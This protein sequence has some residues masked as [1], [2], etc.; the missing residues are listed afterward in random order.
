MSPSPSPAPQPAQPPPSG[1]F[2]RIGK[3]PYNLITYQKSRC[4]YLITR[5][6]VRVALTRGDRTVD[7]MIQAARSGKQ[8]IIEGAK[9]GPTSRETEI[10]LTN[11]AKAS[12]QELREDFLDWLRAND[13]PIWVDGSENYTKARHICGRHND[14]AFYKS[15]I[16]VRQPPAI[17]NIAVVL[18][19]QTD[20][21]LYK[22]LLRLQR[23]F[24]RFG[25]I[26][27]TMSAARRAVR[28][29]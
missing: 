2:L 1:D 15:C 21:L 25:G 23:D 3:N 12:L 9:A 14:D 20:A 5:H 24:L 26:R 19:D 18:I 28:G 8:N 17:A 6:F 7:Q 16:A 13:A 4:I 22:Q 27:E 10:R 29:Y 11:V